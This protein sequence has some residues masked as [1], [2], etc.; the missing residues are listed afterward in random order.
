MIDNVPMITLDEI[1]Q[2]SFSNSVYSKFDEDL[3]EIECQNLTISF[4]NILLVTISPQVLSYVYKHIF[5]LCLILRDV[6]S[7]KLNQSVNITELTIDE[8]REWMDIVIKSHPEENLSKI[9]Y[10][11]QKDI[12]AYILG[13]C[14]AINPKHRDVILSLFMGIIMAALRMLDIQIQKLKLEKV[15]K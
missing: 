6:V 1:I 9:L 4:T 10:D 2:C 12:Y 5:N 13:I 14:D 8:L 3:Y 11:K 15:W 7:V